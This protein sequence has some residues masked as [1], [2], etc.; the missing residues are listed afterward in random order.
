MT[1]DS[2]HISEKEA[3]AKSLAAGW[4][5]R[6]TFSKMMGSNTAHC[7][8]TGVLT[9]LRKFVWLLLKNTHVKE[10]NV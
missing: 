2:S 4:L 8:E 7:I 5:T 3:D 9:P 1:V 10:K 6:G